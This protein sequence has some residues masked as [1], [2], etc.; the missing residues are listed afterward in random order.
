MAIG[1]ANNSSSGSSGGGIATTTSISSPESMQTPMRR[2]FTQASV[3]MGGGSTLT[4]TAGGGGLSSNPSTV[5]DRQYC[6]FLWDVEHQVP[7]PIDE[8][9]TTSSPP[10]R[11]TKTIP[12]YKLSHNQGVLCL[13]WILDEAGGQILAVGGQQRNIQLYDLRISGST[14]TPVA[15]PSPLSTFAHSSGVHGIESDPTRPWHFCTFASTVGEVVKIW[16]V[17]R[18][19]SPL[20]EIKPIGTKNTTSTITSAKWSTLSPGHLSILVGETT[21]STYDTLSTVSRPIFTS[22]S[23]T[24]RTITSFTHYPYTNAPSDDDTGS[25]NSHD[26]TSHKRR[27]MMELF[28]K[29]IVAVCGD[30][31]VNVVS[32]HRIAPLAVSPRSGQIVHSIGQSLFFGSAA[33]GP[34]AMEGSDPQGDNDISAIILRRAHGTD[35]TKYSLDIA[36]N[37]G[38]LTEESLKYCKGVSSSSIEQL[39]RLWKWLKLAEGF[40]REDTPNWPAKSLIDAGVAKL[41][42]FDK[43]K[44]ESQ[45]Y[46][47]SLGCLIFD[48]EGRRCVLKMIYGVKNKFQIVF[49]SLALHL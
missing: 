2:A 42:E 6:C 15:Q 39:L 47:D 34:A 10:I 19:D 13:G 24:D 40:C 44:Q 20:S 9:T 46:S 37:I 36:S 45:S 26:D 1:Y 43:G 38:I 4:G 25:N 48:S 12:L 11:R 23:R 22:T 7:T 30:R 27:V 33:E 18:V 41:L 8:T 29:Q 32:C 16:D 35:N 5:V 21:L 28:P 3:N 31:T 49:A 17:R 14:S